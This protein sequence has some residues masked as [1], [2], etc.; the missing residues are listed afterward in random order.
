V[1]RIA[2]GAA[3]FVARKSESRQPSVPIY[4]LPQ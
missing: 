1:T 2:R 3:T 4:A